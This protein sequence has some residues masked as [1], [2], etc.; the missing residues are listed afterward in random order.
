M[1]NK[2]L[3]FVV[4]F[5][6]CLFYPAVIFPEAPGRIELEAQYHYDDGYNYNAFSYIYVESNLLA[7]LGTGSGD[8]LKIFDIG[9]IFALNETYHQEDMGGIFLYDTIMTFIL[10]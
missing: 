1:I 6:Y 8:F 10:K 7:T 5:L 4:P 9:N 3:A 2:K